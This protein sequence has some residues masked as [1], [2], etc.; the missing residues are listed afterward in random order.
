MGEHFDVLQS[1]I[2]LLDMSPLSTAAKPAKS[3]L[4]IAS[5]L[6][7]ADKILPLLRAKGGAISRTELGDILHDLTDITHATTVMHDVVKLL[8][9]LPSAGEVM[10]EQH[11]ARIEQ[12]ASALMKVLAEF[13]QKNGAQPPPPAATTTMPTT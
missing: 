2:P 1:T 3:A 5:S 12:V 11:Q 8:Y 13:K 6:A 4:T 9:D 10:D 7:V